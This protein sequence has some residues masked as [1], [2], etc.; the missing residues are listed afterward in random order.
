VFKKDAA[1]H[2]EGAPGEIDFKK[3]PMFHHGSKAND[4]F[5]YMPVLGGDET[6]EEAA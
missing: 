4:K 2:V 1:H 5:A 6:K 3:K